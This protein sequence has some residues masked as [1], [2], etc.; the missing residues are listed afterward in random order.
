MFQMLGQGK[1]RIDD[2][3]SK[4]MAL[5]IRHATKLEPFLNDAKRAIAGY[6]GARETEYDRRY[7]FSTVVGQ[8]MG[9]QVQLRLVASLSRRQRSRPPSWKGLAGRR[10]SCRALEV[11]QRNLGRTVNAYQFSI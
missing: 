2:V 11:M 5:H 4:F 6:V 9:R 7:R 10:Y 3:L 8:D 1:Q